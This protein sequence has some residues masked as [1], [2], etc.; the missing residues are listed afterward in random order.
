MLAEN[1]SDFFYTLEDDERKCLSSIER[2]EQ[3]L[4]K[5][6]EKRSQQRGGV[7]L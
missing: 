7:Y 6:R 2:A 4:W 1:R 3:K 5:E